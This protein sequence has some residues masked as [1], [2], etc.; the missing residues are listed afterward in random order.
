[1]WWFSQEVLNPIPALKVP[2]FLANGTQLFG[3]DGETVDGTDANTKAGVQAMTWF[4]QQ[5][6]NPGVKQSGT[7]LL[8]DLKSGKTQAILDGPWGW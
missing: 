2:V 8:A 5:K 6:A 7:A 1:M 4:A 3:K